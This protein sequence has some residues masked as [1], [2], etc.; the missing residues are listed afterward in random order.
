MNKRNLSA[1]I[2]AVTLTPDDNGTLLVGFPDFP[3]ANSVGENEDEALL[4]AVDALETALEIYVDER[5]PIPAPSPAKR[6]Q[7]TVALP[8]MVTAKVLL[9]NEMHAQNLRKADLA[10]LLGVH[11]P[12][13]DRL[14]DL[15][16]SSKLEFVEEAA[17]KLGKRLELSLA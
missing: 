15:R 13:V 6:G 17:S 16:H 2:Y 10:R 3:E 12:Q 11:M 1:L 4:N 5:R 14:F 9:W 8:A 7:H